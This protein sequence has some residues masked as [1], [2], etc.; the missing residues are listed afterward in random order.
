MAKLYGQNASVDFH[1]DNLMSFGKS[2][3]RLNG[4][5]LDK[6]EV[7]YNDLQALKDYAL[8]DAA[9]VGQRVVYIDT[10]ANTVTN[11]CIQ[12]DGSLSEIGISPI[13]DEKSIVVAED[14]TVSLAGISGLTFTEENDEGEEVQIKYQPLMTSAGLTWVRPSATTVEGLAAEIEALKVDIAALESTVGN[15][16]SG[17]VKGV[18][19]NTTNVA[20]INE[21]IGTV[22]EG[23]TVVEMI[24]DAQEAATYDDTA[25]AGRVTTAEGEI[26]TLQEQI[27]NVYTKTDVYTK[28]EADTAI[29][30]A[31]Q[32]AIDAIIGEAGIDEKY[33]TLREVADWIL[34]DT[35][36]SAQLITRVDNIEKDYLKGADKTE[37]Q[38]EI[39]ALEEFVGALPEGAASTT[40]VAYIQEV[41]DALK[42]GDYA[43]ASDLTEL[44][45]RVTT[46]ENKLSGIEDGAQANK[47]ETV[48]ETQFNIDSDR[49]LS[50][51]DVPMEKVDG[52]S[53]ALAGKVNV[54]DGKRLMTDAEGTKLE[55]IEAGA[56]V[57]KIDS[58][59]ET[60][61][62]IDESKKLTL[63]EVAMGKVS[64]LADALDGK[65]NRGSTLADYGI[66]DAYTK[67]ETESRIQEVLDGLSDTSETAASV[68]QAL[69]T[70][71]TSNDQRVADIETEVAEKV[72]A[73]EGKSLVSDTL[74][75]KL[76]GIEESA[77]VNKIESVKLGDS[78][79]E[80]SEKCVTI[81]IG[82]GLKAT[83]E[84]TISSDGSLGVGKVNVNKLVQTEGEAFI[85]NGG[86]SAV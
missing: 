41:V 70:Y 77:Q 62:A 13:G 52:L 50:L 67:T 45:G 59:D 82:A 8:T 72:T 42:I 43:K 9:F 33:D 56:Q 24:E 39:D 38:N 27:A 10:T 49:K 22:A 4:Q 11:F 65:A 58:V 47:I 48:D 31:K 29:A 54:E 73:E 28:T 20:A 32:E 14:G 60:Q 64:G 83:D 3:S 23:K 37:L 17:L 7:W 25:L 30:T 34:A 84:V 66:T 55:G 85:L 12:V 6:S 81:P 71:K 76:E 74:I 57:N 69:E 2:F 46:I 36:S 44:A 80:I 26:D 75:S 51:L 53:D 5:P 35:T 21:K 16:E 18:A 61:F 86:T 78:L 1:A 19:D 68:A 79:L 15:A 40:V 63:I